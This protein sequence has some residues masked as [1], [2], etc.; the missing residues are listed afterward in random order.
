[1]TKVRL[2]IAGVGGIATDRHI[3]AFRN[4]EQVEITHVYDINT[5]RAMVVANQFQIPHVASSYEEMLDHIDAVVITTP[6][7]FHAPLTIAALE[8]NI[9]VMCEKPMA[10]TQAEADA[11]V[12]AEEKSDGVLHIAYHYR[13]MKEAI[14]AKKI[15]D[16]GIIGEPLV[17]RVKAMRR[18]KV[19]GWGVFTN[20]ELQGGGALIDYGCHLL[21]LAMWLTGNQKPVEVSAQTY[22]SLSRMPNP[23]NEWGVFNPETFEVD[24]HVTAFIRFENNVTMLFET[25]WAANVESDEEHISISGTKGGLN[26]F[27]MKVNQADDTLM[28]T[29]NIDY[30]QIDHPFQHLQAENFISAITDGTPLRVQST[31]AKDVSSVIEAIYLSAQK[32]QAIRIEGE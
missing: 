28:T 19:P 4:F 13:F 23:V 3:P 32:Q 1:M 27:E 30:I 22:N 20:K 10:T 11:M 8:K 14:A 18:R 2:G 15:I 5:E 31:E 12:K 29:L 26:V 21:D 7:K 25:S 17:V 16:K 6:N 24:D 9:S